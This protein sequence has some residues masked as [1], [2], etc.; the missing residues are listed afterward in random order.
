MSDPTVVT[1]VDATTPGWSAKLI[2]A[3]L[4]VLGGLPMSGLFDSHPSVL[5]MLGLVIGALGAIG[6]GGH[7]V[8][9][10]RAHAA[11]KVAA[12]PTP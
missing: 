1:P 8:M 4:F 3:L 9:L 11:G 7:A 2:V 12:A 5:K 10:K 6:Y